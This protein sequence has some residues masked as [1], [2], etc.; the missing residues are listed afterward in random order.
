[1]RNKIL[2]MVQLPPPIHGA[3][4]RNK[5]LV[6]SKILNDSFIIKVL[7]LNFANEV[8]DIGKIS[9]LKLY[10]MFSYFFK[11]IFSIIFFRP[12]LAYFTISPVGGSFYRDALFVVIVKI[13][14]I[15]ILYHLRGKGIRKASESSFIN[16]LIYKYV[17]NNSYVICL[18]EI[19][20]HDIKTVYYKEPY[21]VNNGINVEIQDYEIFPSSNEVPTIL[22]LSNLAREKGIVEFLLALNIINN[23][24]IKFCANIIGS[25]FDITV[26]QVLDMIKYYNLE[27]NVFYIGPK[28]GEEKKSYYLNSDIFVF[29]TYYK[30]EVFPGVI[31]EAMQ[32][33]KPIVTTFEASIPDIIEQGVT[34]FMV[35]QK[36]YR[37]LAEKIEQLIFDDD[38]RI[39]MGKQARVRFLEKYTLEKFEL[40]M[41]KVFKDV[42][43]K[44]GT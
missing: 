42:L 36:N 37:V 38:L 31:L 3:S 22:F 24:N 25:E 11:L 16:Q 35:P 14:R 30:N 8:N 34:G 10:R 32:A 4:L 39:R 15:K 19:P 43:S 9:F 5:S 40:N 12:N 17:F 26:E 44:N 13:F 33:A 21:I 1:M 29:P 7:P 2:F 41:K 6:D 18:S 27:Q 20:S 28:Y 23:K